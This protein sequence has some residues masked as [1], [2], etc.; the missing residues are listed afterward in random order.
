MTKTYKQNKAYQIQQSDTE[1][2]KVLHDGKILA[3]VIDIEE[4]RRVIWLNTGKGEYI[5]EADFE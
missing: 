1:W 2:C 3:N 5:T 4:A